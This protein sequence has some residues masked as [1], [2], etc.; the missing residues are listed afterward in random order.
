MDLT[1]QL[2][3]QLKEITNTILESKEDL[4]KQR[5]ITDHHIYTDETNVSLNFWREYL[6]EIYAHSISA[7]L[8][9]TFDQLEKW[10]KDV[11]NLL[12]NLQIPLDVAIEEI[13]FYRD[14]IGVIIKEEAK[15]KQF[16]FDTFYEVLSRYD[17]VVDQAVH[18]LSLSYSREHAAT[19]NAAEYSIQELAIPIVRVTEDIGVIPLIG[20]L[21]TKRAQQLMD[22]ALSEGAAFNLTYI[23][24]DLSGVPIIDTMVA[25]QIFKVIS[26]LKM[27]GIQAKITGIRPEIAITM[28]N[29]GIKFEDIFTYSSL[30]LA[31]KQLSK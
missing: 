5:Q 16:T 11:V 2:N 6:I 27:M 15:A 3:Q 12:V 20:E 10:G 29:L 14:S 22:T 24:I 7:E 4:A 26:A 13:R 30:H 23:I 1:L 18:W 19:I 17:L 8:N 21:D 28:V 9:K 31:I 25:S